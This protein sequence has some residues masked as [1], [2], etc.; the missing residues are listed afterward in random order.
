MKSEKIKK[1]IEKNEK[2]NSLLNELIISEESKNFQYIIKFEYSQSN[3]KFYSLL[4]KKTGKVK[5]DNKERIKSYLKIRNI[6]NEEI[7]FINE[8]I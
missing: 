1:V 4:D 5:I 7:Y 2:L 8:K 3:I 6:K